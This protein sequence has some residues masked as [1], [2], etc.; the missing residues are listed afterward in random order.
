MMH[1]KEKAVLISIALAALETV[2]QDEKPGKVRFKAADMSINIILKLMRFYRHET[3]PPALI[4]KASA[5]LDDMNDRIRR[6]FVEE[7][8]V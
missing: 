4:S 2:R 7:V 8:E 1:D 6:E 3:F 5:I